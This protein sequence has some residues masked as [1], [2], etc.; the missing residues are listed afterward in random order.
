MSIVSNISRSE[1]NVAMI[2]CIFLFVSN[3]LGQSH[4]ILIVGL[5]IIVTLEGPSA[6]LE[7]YKYQVVV[8]QG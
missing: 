1:S 8:L 6:V 4:L 5:P 7:D 3:R 2:I